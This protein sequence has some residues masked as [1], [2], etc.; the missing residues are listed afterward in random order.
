MESVENEFDK[1]LRAELNQLN[2]NEDRIKELV[3]L[4]ADISGAFLLDAIFCY[5]TKPT[6]GKSLDTKYFKLFIEL[7]ADVNYDEYGWTC[8]EEAR[9]SQNAELIEMLT[10][11]NL[12]NTLES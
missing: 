3:K 11:R 10:E 9:L 1:L 4:G 2:P 12:V 5:T 6:E 8:L 7:G